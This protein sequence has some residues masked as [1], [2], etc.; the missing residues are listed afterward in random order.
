MLLFSKSTQMDRRSIK[1]NVINIGVIKISDRVFPC[2][3]SRWIPA[4]SNSMQNEVQ[5]NICKIL[6][7]FA[8]ALVIVNKVMFDHKLHWEYFPFPIT[9]F[10]SNG[11][12][13]PSHILEITKPYN[14]TK[15]NIVKF[16]SIN[17]LFDKTE[18]WGYGLTI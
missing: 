15:I 6:E 5:E 4:D 1:V 16:I 10:G 11:H 14:Y 8:C 13:D 17:F 12:F 3:L 9:K 7:I 2:W 18:F